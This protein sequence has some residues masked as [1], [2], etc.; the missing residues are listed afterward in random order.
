MTCAARRTARQL[1]S[2]GGARVYL[3]FF[4]KEL[5]L[6]KAAGIAKKRPFGVAHASELPFV[7]AIKPALLSSAERRLSESFVSYWTSFATD[8]VP[9]AG[10]AAPEWP[11]YNA[12][13]DALL[14]LDETI[15]V[16]RGLKS[17]DC[18]FWDAFPHSAPQGSLVEER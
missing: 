12:S 5:D 16:S 11:A 8:A 3:Y 6:L 18:D 2:G 14:V 10:S 7:F 4:T 17:A 15:S 9:T 1:A 13:A